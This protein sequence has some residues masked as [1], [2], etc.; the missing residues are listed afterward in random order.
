MNYTASTYKTAQVRPWLI[1]ICADY[2]LVLNNK[3]QAI[4][5]TSD[6]IG[7][8]RIYMGLTAPVS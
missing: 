1:S 6:D 7:Y 3:R 4:I 5:W 8:W 2:G